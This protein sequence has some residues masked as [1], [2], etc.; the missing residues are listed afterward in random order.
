MSEVYF[1]HLTRSPVEAALAQLLKRALAAD[2]RVA[3][4][5]QDWKRMDWLDEKLWLGPEEEFLPHG[6]AGQPHAA[7]QP[8]LLTTSAEAEN[9]P[10]CVM[11]VDG[12]EVTA[13]DL[14]ALKRACILFDGH[15]TDAL[16]RARDQWRRLTAAGCAA[17]YWSEEGGRWE[18]KAEKPAS[19]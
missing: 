18:K 7:R 4:R 16:N 3:V 6:R 8:V 9:A 14:A 12:A 15:D 11:S 13:E 19:A 10:H 2:W 17:Q 5:G 1:Y